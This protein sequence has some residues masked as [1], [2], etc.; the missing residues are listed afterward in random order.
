MEQKNEYDL[1][2]LITWCWKVFLRY[3]WNPFLF[4]VRFG[5]KKWYFLLLAAG[6]GFALAYFIPKCYKTTYSGQMIVKARVCQSSDYVNSLQALGTES[7]KVIMS[8]LGVP[9]NAMRSYRGIFPHYVYPMDTLSTGYVVDQKNNCLN[10]GK[11]VVS[12]LFAVEVRSTDS[13]TIRLWGDAFVN[14]FK[15]DPYIQNANNIRLAELRNNIKVLQNELTLLDSLRTIEY[16]E[17]SKHTI[18]LNGKQGGNML[19]REQ[20]RLMHN[21]LLDLHNRIL[22]MQNSLTY[23]SEPVDV[24]SPMSLNAVPLTHWTTTYKKYMVLSVFLMYGL[25]LVWHFRK[26]IISFAK[27]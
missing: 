13:A 15:K 4:L 2:D 14:Y 20:T 6:I 25:L 12:N 3:A 1:L 22:Y 27:Q 24:I 23:L 19:I 10:S 18:M 17:N 16:L 11:S 7:G 8:K 26:E 9:A 5:L 21:D